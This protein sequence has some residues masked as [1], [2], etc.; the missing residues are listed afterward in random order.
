MNT[1]LYQVEDASQET[2]KRDIEV[3]KRLGTIRVEVYIANG[4]KRYLYKGNEPVEGEAF[5]LAEKSMKGRE[6]THGTR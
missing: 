1:D 3:A 4:K 6:L 2:V 5:K